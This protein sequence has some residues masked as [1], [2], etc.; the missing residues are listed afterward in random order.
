MPKVLS[1]KEV[2]ESDGP[3][4]VF[5]GIIKLVFERQ[6][7]T[8][9]NGKKWSREGLIL[10]D[11]RDT[12]VEILVNVWDHPELGF[13]AGD[14]LVFVAAETSK[15]WSG[16]ELK[17]DKF[18]TKKKDDGRTYYCLDVKGDATIMDHTEFSPGDSGGEPQPD[19]RTQRRPERQAQR[20][21]TR[22][23]EQ[24]AAGPTMETVAR[25]LNAHGNMYLRC[26]ITATRVAWE[27]KE[28]MGIEMIAEDIRCIG[29]TLYMDHKKRD[30]LLIMPTDEVVAPK[31]RKMLEPAPE[32][33]EPEM[34]GEQPDDPLPF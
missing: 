11:H 3:I 24:P 4:P 25:S 14:T 18:K 27:L 8:T 23:T 26:L 19:R 32:P 34:V 6:K 9:K 21:A 13:E 20:E 7:G 5:K 2:Y 31:I 10:V 16:I 1:I 15:G 17:V 29:T 22:T 33:E 12:D 28:S 30:A